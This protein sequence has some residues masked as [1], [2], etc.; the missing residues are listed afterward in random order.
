[1]LDG[2]GLGAGQS[3]AF[4]LD[5]ASGTATEGVDFSALIAGNLASGL[6]FTTSAGAN[7]AINVVVTNNG[8]DLASGSSLIHF[9][10]PTIQDTLVEGPETFPVTLASGTVTVTTGL[11]TTTIV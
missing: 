7:G 11:V 9:A 3:V 8:P 2:V 4:T 5:T 10:I 1:V 6:S